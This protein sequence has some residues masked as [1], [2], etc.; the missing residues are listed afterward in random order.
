MI[1]VVAISDTHENFHRQE[2]IPPA[3]LLIHCGDFTNQG[4]LKKVTEFAD[5][6]RRISENYT[7]IIIVAGNHD[8]SFDEPEP[9]RGHQRLQEDGPSNIIYLNH[10]QYIYN[11]IVIFGSPYTPRFGDWAF[12]VE[13]G[14][15]LAEK[16]ADIPP[17]TNILITHGPARGILDPGRSEKNV[18]CDQLAERIAIVKPKLHVFG[19]CHDGYG[20]VQCGETLHVNAASCDEQHN[21]INAP[22][23][24]YI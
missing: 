14:S 11:D 15:A 16:W 13:R 5:W 21:L 22:Q 20:K 10:S 2:D 4:S 24:I 23:V 12:N 9:S 19:H 1:K 17:N 3:D 8:R 6:L 7:N 18:G